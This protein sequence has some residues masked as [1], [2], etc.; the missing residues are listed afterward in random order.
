MIVENLKTTI[1]IF[2]HQMVATTNESE[3]KTNLTN[4][5]TASLTNKQPLDNSW[6]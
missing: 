6:S 4:R 2:I 3:N 5:W 1:Y